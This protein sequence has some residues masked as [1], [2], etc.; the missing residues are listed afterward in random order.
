MSSKLLSERMKESAYVRQDHRV[1]PEEG[2]TL[3]EVLAP[4]YWAHVAG[5]MHVGDKVEIFPDGG[6]Y[7]AECLVV[8]CS[9]LHAKL[10]VLLEKQFH[11]PTKVAKDA[12]KEPLVV[13]FK[14]P[15]RK[16]SVIRTK[17]LEIVKEQFASKEE[18]TAWLEENKADILG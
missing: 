15:Q 11:A 3:E 9:R 16:W 10:V 17:D 1:T 2:T 14:G 5:R 6:A 8:S 18:A 12:K 4:D 13:E 7:Y